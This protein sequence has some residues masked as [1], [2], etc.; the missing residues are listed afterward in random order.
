MRP[1][2]ITLILCAIAA[3]LVAAGC[4]GGSQPATAQPPTAQPESALPPASPPAAPPTAAQPAAGQPPTATTAP[5]AGGID[6]S[7]SNQP[8][9]T[10]AGTVV[11]QMEIAVKPKGK[12]GE[13]AIAWD[14]YKATAPFT[15]K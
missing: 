15:V 10:I 13:I 14:V 12:G 1:F 6:L 3:L 7:Q 2:R 11:E 8:G 9:S 4:G 5:A